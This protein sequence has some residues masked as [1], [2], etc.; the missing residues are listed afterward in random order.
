[1]KQSI[2]NM[3][4]K[5]FTNTIRLMAELPPFRL[6]LPLRGLELSETTL[7]AWL[8]MQQLD[9]SINGDEA[10]LILSVGI[11]YTIQ[12]EHK[13]EHLQVPVVSVELMDKNETRQGLVM[14]FNILE[15]TMDLLCLV[16]ELVEE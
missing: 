2:E 8:D 12:I 1:M 14:R 15:P 5:S 6:V 4:L 11:T 3:E 7:V 10:D 9:K 13:I 16:H